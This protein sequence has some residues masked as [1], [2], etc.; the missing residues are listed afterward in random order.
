MRVSRREPGGKAACCL[1]AAAALLAVC[2]GR[3]QELLRDG[4]LAV[5]EGQDAGS[6]IAYVRISLFGENS[7]GVSAARPALTVECIEKKGKRRV[8][9]YVDFGDADHSFHPPPE[10]DRL[11]HFLPH[12]P[13]VRLTLA[14]KDYKS[15]KLA[16]EVMPTHEYKYRAPGLGNPNLEEVSSVLRFMSLVPVV[17]VSYADQKVSEQSAEFNTAG[18][19]AEMNRTALCKP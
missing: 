2:S 4:T 3:P 12:N 5:K 18:L 11:T 1:F 17:R 6:E 16:W 19:I 7:G 13:S 9:L 15:F 14:F 8:G 10:R